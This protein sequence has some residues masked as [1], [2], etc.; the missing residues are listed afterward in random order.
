MVDEGYLSTDIC[1]FQDD[2]LL[3]EEITNEINIWLTDSVL[4]TLSDEN[5]H[6]NDDSLSLL[7][8]D[9]I[10]VNSLIL[11]SID[12]S[13]SSYTPVDSPKS[14]NT[15]KSEIC[16]DNTSR[17]DDSLSIVLTPSVIYGAEMFPSILSAAFN[18]GD[19]DYVQSI[20][21]AYISEKCTFQ[22]NKPAY[23]HSQYGNQAVL[24]FYSDALSHCP[25]SVVLYRGV[26]KIPAPHK[27]GYY[28]KIKTH[29]SGTLIDKSDKCGAEGSITEFLSPKTSKADAEAIRLAEILI[30]QQQKHLKV[31]FKGLTYLFINESTHKIENYDMSLSLSSIRAAEG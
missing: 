21:L 3:T 4:S 2:E 9:I 17:A 14:S 25:D 15:S 31:F 1:L 23:S 16:S 5:T 24:K 28:L 30:H 22:V 29:M 13:S 19:L 12:D 8:S 10:S 26:K 6:T 11:S 7:N 20:I 18:Q 27:Q